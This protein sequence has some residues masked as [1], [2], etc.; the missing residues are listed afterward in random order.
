VF[1]DRVKVR[2]KGGDGGNGCVSFRREKFVPFGGPDGGDG[3][4]GGSIIFHVSSGET[5]LTALHGK[6]HYE[7]RKGEHGKGRLKHGATG[8]D[9]LLPVPPGTIVKDLKSDEIIAELLSDDA[10][11][12][13]AQ[14]GRGGKGNAHFTT[15]Q[16]RAPRISQPGQPG[17]ER[18]LLV[19]LK[20]VAQ[21]GLVGL[22]NA[23]KSTLLSKITKAHPRIADYPF[24]TL[25]PVLGTMGMP[26]DSHIILAD[27]PGIVQGAH[28]G[29]GLGLEFLRHIERT[30]FLVFVLDL[31]SGPEWPPEKAYETLVNEIVSYQADII[32]RPQ[33]IVFNKSDLVDDEKEIQQSVKRT[34]DATRSPV[35]NTFIISAKNE[36]GI[37]GLKDYLR[38]K[39]LDWVNSKAEECGSE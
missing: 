12:V 27:I 2:V 4:D 17:E 26:D 16:R 20:L 18:Q 25:Y 14:G 24:T 7:A 23:G 32:E 5:T 1:I 30:V 11:T 37:D 8:P 39:A 22:P 3:G 31:S 33:V 36:D 6:P 28:D 10:S 9:I 15:A 21:G 13:V 29:I 34:L 38:D 35:E 19:E